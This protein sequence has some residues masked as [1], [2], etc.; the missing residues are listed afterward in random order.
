MMV[1]NTPVLG[2]SNNNSVDMPCRLS[3]LSYDEPGALRKLQ[4]SSPNTQPTL[5]SQEGN[6]AAL[7][8]MSIQQLFT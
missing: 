8:R 4:G 3:K 7:A 2:P 1:P 6:C 5:H